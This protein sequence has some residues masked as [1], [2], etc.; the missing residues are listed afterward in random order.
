MKIKTK[1]ILAFLIISLFAISFTSFIAT[2]TI[3]EKYKDYEKNKI[4]NSKEQVEALFYDQLSELKRKLIMLAN[5]KEVSKNLN[6]KDKLYVDIS[7]KFFL[8]EGLNFGIFDKNFNLILHFKGSVSDFVDIKGL[9]EK[10]LPKK[11][12]EAYL[13]KAEIFSINNKLYFIAI[14]PIVD[15]DNFNVLGYMV[16]ERPIDFAFAY[17]LKDRSK[18]DIIILSK[19]NKIA[20]TITNEEGKSFF[21]SS[22]NFNVKKISKVKINDKEYYTTGF[23][24]KDNAEKDVG[25]VYVLNSLESMILAQKVF[26]KNFI[27]II[28]I[29]SLILIL[30]AFFLTKIISSPILALSEGA[31]EISRG[32]YDIEIKKVSNDE[33][34]E[35]TEIFNQMVVSIKSQRAEILSLQRF[36]ENIFKN[37][38]IA[39]LIC[40]K[41]LNLKMINDEAERVFDIN[42][43]EVL[44]KRLYTVIPFMRSYIKEILNLSPTEEPIYYDN[45]EFKKK[46][47]KELIL[48]M[49]FYKISLENEEYIVIQVEDITKRIRIEERLVQA[50]KL[51]SIGEI[52]SKF[53]HEN[54]NLLSAVLGQIEILKMKIKEEELKR[55]ILQV[56]KLVKKSLE[57]SDSI[58]DFSKKKKILMKKIL[59]RKIVDDLVDFLKI[60]VLKNIDVKRS[61]PMEK[62]YVR[63]NEEKI[64]V[65]IM[66]LLINAKDAIEE[67][68]R[69]KG[70][71]NIKLKPFNGLKGDFL[72]LSI[73]DNGIGIKEENLE[74]IFDS[75][76]TT[77]GER[78]TGLGLANVKEIINDL[79]GFIKVK[80]KYGEG[81]TFYIYFPI[82]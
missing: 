36:L 53:S 46:K 41:E 44:D 60:T 17:Y 45:I 7:S 69:E 27:Y 58:L 72:Q 5:F 61:Y 50:N 47:N 74:R 55:K 79:G 16:L 25:S 82:Y 23:S 9:K 57:L 43:E 26:F 67:A 28:V 15:Q 52:L 73:Q 32:N 76:Y 18:S 1:L 77:K 59:I 29:I 40:D 8:V 24:I 20:S 33:I 62:Y 31:K 49:I 11:E 71:I 64:S 37:L 75:Y 19:N 22:K 78:G 21:F 12:D 63:A 56:E 38:T 30:V 51:I 65:V 68:K 6:N 2:R 81:T 48:R 4:I 13:R 3:I 34:G 66:N 14:S 42:K 35:L 39:L 10:V 70:I 54:N 80:S